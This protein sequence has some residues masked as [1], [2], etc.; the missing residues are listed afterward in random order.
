MHRLI[1]FDIAGAAPL[2][3]GAALHAEIERTPKVRQ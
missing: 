1:R 2:V 3:P